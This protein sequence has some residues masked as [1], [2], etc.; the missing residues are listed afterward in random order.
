MLPRKSEDFRL[1]VFRS[2]DVLL[3]ILIK[4]LKVEPPR[5]HLLVLITDFFDQNANY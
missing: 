3:D 4:E 5:G 2:L 1:I